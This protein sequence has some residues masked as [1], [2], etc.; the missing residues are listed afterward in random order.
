[1]GL[2]STILVDGGGRVPRWMRFL[3]A[4]IRHPMTFA[5]SLSVRRW[6]ERTVILLVMQSIDNSL[7]LLRKRSWFGSRI[8]SAH[9]TGKPNPRYLPVA[10]RSARAAGSHMGGFGGSSLNEVMLNIPMTAHILGGACVADSAEAGVID[11]YHRVFGH[12]GL[13]V[14]DGAAVA[15][16]LGV[17][18]SLTITAMAERAMAMWPNIGGSDPRPSLGSAYDAVDP[19]PPQ[20]PAVPA[21]SMGEL[22]PG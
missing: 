11:P 12:P 9:D 21:G 14:V 16:N 1:M 13:H 4:A 19:V 20:S 15:A 10:N 5:R 7:R 3:A 22:R 17:N 8:T 2:L 6:S 18:P